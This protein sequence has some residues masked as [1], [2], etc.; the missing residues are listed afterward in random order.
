MTALHVTR[1]P[2]IGAGCYSFKRYMTALHVTRL[3]HIG[4]GCYSFK[5]YMT[6]LHVTRLPDVERAFPNISPHQDTSKRLTSLL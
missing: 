3:P 4:A 1:L 5:R 6:A 2:H